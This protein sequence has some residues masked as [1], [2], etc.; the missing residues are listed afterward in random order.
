VSERERE[1]KKKLGDS[2]SLT[3]S[4][5]SICARLLFIYFFLLFAG[6][7]YFFPT[8]C[9]TAQPSLPPFGNIV[10]TYTF[11]HK[12][13]SRI[14]RDRTRRAHTHTPKHKR[15]YI[16]SIVCT[17]IYRHIRFWRFARRC[18]VLFGFASMVAV[19][20][21]RRRLRILRLRWIR[22][23]II[24]SKSPTTV[25][26]IWKQFLSFPRTYTYLFT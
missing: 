18:I 4:F 9:P 23:T 20:C 13:T 8:F 21:K 2:V 11:A 5:F 6:W 25:Q 15:V 17:N 10:Y 12:R 3:K 26:R 24:L 14:E 19:I 7:F 16:I 1:I 22:S